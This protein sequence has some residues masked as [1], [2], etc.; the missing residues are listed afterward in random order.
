MNTR[1]ST[2]IALLVLQVIFLAGINQ[3]A[4][5]D[6]AVTPGPCNGLPAPLGDVNADCRYNLVD[7]VLLIN[8]IMTFP[9]DPLPSN[10]D[11]NCDHNTDIQDVVRLID[12]VFAKGPV[13]QPCPHE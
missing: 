1:K 11:V 13:L 12:F 6:P 9:G 7:V 10:S 5:A 3:M 4:V 2:A 8:A